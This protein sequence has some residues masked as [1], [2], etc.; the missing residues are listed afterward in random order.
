MT[1]I[2]I[3]NDT[4]NYFWGKRERQCIVNGRCQYMAT[5]YSKGCA[6]G[7]LL[8]PETAAS[9]PQQIGVSSDPV[10]SKLPLWMKDL[11]QEFLSELQDLHDGNWLLDG[12]KHKH[13]KKQFAQYVDTNQ[14]IFP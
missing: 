4:L 13:V 6:I 9:L 5:S 7:R 14:I 2:E 8:N 11:G 3:L 12:D 1:R 10:F